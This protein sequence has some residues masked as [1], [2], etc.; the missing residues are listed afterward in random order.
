M[1]HVFGLFDGDAE[2]ADAQRLLEEEGFG[3]EVVRVIDSSSQQTTQPGVP[4]VAGGLLN[5]SVGNVNQGGAPAI[6][7]FAFQGLRDYDL[8]DE[9]ADFLND[10]LGNGASLLIL[11]TDRAEMA[12]MVLSRSGAQRTFSK[13]GDESGNARPD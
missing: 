3:D 7:A 1:A 6:G 9:E 4:L 8:M 10:A 13:G 5:T 11:E 12:E 2:L